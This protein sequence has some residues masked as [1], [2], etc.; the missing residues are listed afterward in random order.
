MAPTSRSAGPAGRRTAHAPARQREAE[1]HDRLDLTST[2]FSLLEVLVRHAGR[3]AGKDALS[4]AA[5]GRPLLRFDRSIDVHM[6]SIR[7]KLGAMPMAVPDPHRR[8]QGY[9]L[10]KE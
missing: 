9:Q 7:R 1:W 3:V 2:E 8:A 5:L 6:G 4:E 10:V